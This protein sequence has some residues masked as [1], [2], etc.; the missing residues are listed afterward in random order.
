MVML[1]PWVGLVSAA[2]AG[3]V[4]L[5]VLWA[6]RRRRRRHPGDD[7][8]TIANLQ[9]AEASSVFRKLRRRYHLLLGGEV[10]ALS[11]V[12]L[13]AV[14]LTMRPITDRELERDVR[15]RDVMLCLDVSTSMNQLDAIVL[16]Q[17]A[18]LAEG[19]RGERIGLT[20]FNGSA[21]TVFPLTDDADFVASTL[22]EAA[23]A[24]GQ[25]KR[26]FVEGTEEGGTSLIGD[27]LASC[28]M[29][30]DEDQRGR[31]RSIVFATDNA[32]AG[33]PILSLQEAAS[34]VRGRG[35]RVYAIAAADR[36]TD[37]DGADLREAAEST[38]GAY[39]ETDGENTTADVVAEVGEMEAT[40][41]DV[42]PEVVADDKPT[43]WIVSCLAGLGA[44][45]AVGWG[46]KR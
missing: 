17:F 12:G 46:L 1:Q 8:V 42:P 38:G 37:D 18:E 22:E 21:I 10:A 4:M 16:R 41:L 35:I 6:A 40:R 25:R 3:A 30:F 11:V 24:L 36:I 26:S 14:G 44:L 19:L 5:A 45:F 2:A 28:A 34:M 32:L 20:I 9:H 31:S 39:F 23:S 29:R 7:E 15:N 33:V 43:V 27:G 13:S